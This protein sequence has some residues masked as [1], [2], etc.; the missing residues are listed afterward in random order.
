M[1]QLAKN[2]LTVLHGYGSGVGQPA[3]RSVQDV[4]AAIAEAQTVRENVLWTWAGW[5]AR[6]SSYTPKE[7]KA[8]WRDYIFTDAEVEE[9]VRLWV[10]EFAAGDSMKEDTRQRIRALEAGEARRDQNQ[11]RKVKERAFEVYLRQKFGD[12]RL[13]RLFV[14]FPRAHAPL[15]ALEYKQLKRVAAD[16]GEFTRR[17]KRKHAASLDLL[18][19]QKH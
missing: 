16:Q 4:E 3:V 17:R 11:A 7:W 18:N 15:L 8:W 14:K 19:L 13:G 5:Q 10:L 1:R 2:V 12:A 6:W 9:A